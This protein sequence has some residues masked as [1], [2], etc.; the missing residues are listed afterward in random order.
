MLRLLRVFRNLKLSHF[1]SEA[2][3]RGHAGAGAKDH[4][5]HGRV[6]TTMLIAGSLIYLLEGEENAF[7][8]IRVSSLRHSFDSLLFP[9]LNRCANS[10]TI[11][12]R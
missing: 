8:I 5:F 6:T 9:A 1:A 3:V 11:V 12:V 7:T 10:G 4:R 2:R